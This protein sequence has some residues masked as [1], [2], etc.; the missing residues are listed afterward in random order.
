[1]AKIDLKKV[2]DEKL[3]SVLDALN[4]QR[5]E[6]VEEIRCITAEQRRRSV[7]AKIKAELEK[8]PEE[9]RKAILGAVTG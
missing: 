5:G 8:V 9:Q 4:G 2:S 6:I 7:G 3:Q 1:M